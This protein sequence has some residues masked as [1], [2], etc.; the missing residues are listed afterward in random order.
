[1]V[2]RGRKLEITAEQVLRE[3]ALMGFANVMDYFTPQADGTAYVDS[4]GLTR[5]QA[6][7]ITEL[8]V[9]A[10]TSGRGTA[11]REVKRV[12]LKLAD[13]S[14]NLELIGKHLGLFA[15]KPGDN[16]EEGKSGGIRLSDTEL[17]QRI[18]GVLARAGKKRSGAADT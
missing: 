12:K 10:F 5:D 11:A 14:R 15:R 2:G 3:I 6:A 8:T 1:M 17:A 13:K 7:A 16:G 9:E 18:L 4:S